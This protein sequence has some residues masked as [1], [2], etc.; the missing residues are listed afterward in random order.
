MTDDEE[1]VQF[2]TT[3]ASEEVAIPVA[4]AIELL[5]EEIATPRL[6]SG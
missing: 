4:A 1:E 5:D 2:V 3:V 6:E